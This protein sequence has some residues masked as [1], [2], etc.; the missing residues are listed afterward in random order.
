MEKEI[1]GDER[2]K[3]GFEQHMLEE[4]RVRA[5]WKSVSLNRKW[6]ATF[7][8]TEMHGANCINAARHS[9]TAH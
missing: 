7:A 2:D 3:R 9:A 1:R 4:D 8:A 5:D 6:H